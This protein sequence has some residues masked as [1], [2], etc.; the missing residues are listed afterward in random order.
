V[1]LSH[2]NDKMMTITR[3]TMTDIEE[4]EQESRLV[5]ARVERLER[6]LADAIATERVNALR[7]VRDACK[8]YGKAGE[9]VYTTFKAAQAKSARGAA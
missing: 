5:R 2:A 1:A 3:E 6:E 7:M 9:C 4:L 8:P